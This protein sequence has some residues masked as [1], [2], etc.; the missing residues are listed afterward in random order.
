MLGAYRIAVVVLTVAGVYI[1]LFWPTPPRWSVA[2]ADFDR[3]T[4]SDHRIV[5][6]TADQTVLVTDFCLPDSSHYFVQRWS[7]ATGEL[8]GESDWSFVPALNR[9]VE[10][11]VSPDGR[12]LA[13]AGITRGNAD[14]PHAWLLNIQGNTLIADFPVGGAFNAG[15]F[16]AVL[17]F[18]PDGRWFARLDRRPADAV[19]DV[20]RLTTT[21]DPSTEKNIRLSGF[22]DQMSLN[23]DG[24]TLAVDVLDSA[25][26]RKRQAGDRR[27]ELIDL[28]TGRTSV[29]AHGR[30]RS[31]FLTDGRLAL[32]G[33]PRDRQFQRFTV[34]AGAATPYGRGIRIEDFF[35]DGGSFT[36]PHFHE[37]NSAASGVVVKRSGMRGPE[38]FYHIAWDSGA[39]TRRGEAT[40]HSFFEEH[41]ARELECLFRAAPDGSLAASIDHHGRLRVWDIGQPYW[42]HRPWVGLVGIVLAGAA[43]AAAPALTRRREK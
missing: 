22:L 28:E 9:R 13:V 21:A 5:G 7:V 6:F 35:R 3:A 4:L 2:L 31:T 24:T 38:S 26:D 20:V 17:A 8:L 37:G 42:P 33:G 23:P 14:H 39:R 30:W 40:V 41:T 36:D 12:F 15:P 19:T 11:A 29:V 16:N 25:F 1:T 27:C 34:S 18:S 32:A 10:T 43:L